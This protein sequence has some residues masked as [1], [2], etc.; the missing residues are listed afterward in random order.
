MFLLL[1]NS[2]IPRQLFFGS[3]KNLNRKQF[4]LVPK[5]RAKSSLQ[6]PERGM[7]LICPLN[8]KAKQED[9]EI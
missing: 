3:E 7:K 9:L 8:S 1:Q 5:K 6:L 2:P 4:Y